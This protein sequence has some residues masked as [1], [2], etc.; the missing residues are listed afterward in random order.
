MTSVLT[1]AACWHGKT[2]ADAQ[3]MLKSG[4]LR[5]RVNEGT[6]DERVVTIELRDAAGG[7]VERKQSGAKSRSADES[8]KS[9]SRIGLIFWWWWWSPYWYWW[10]WAP[11]G[12]RVRVYGPNDST[13]LLD[14]QVRIGLREVE[15]TDVGC[16]IPGD[17]EEKKDKD[18]F[19]LA[20]IEIT[21]ENGEPPM[22]VTSVVLEEREDEPAPRVGITVPRLRPKRKKASLDTV[23]THLNLENVGEATLLV[24]T[25]KEDPTKHPW[26]GLGEARFKYALSSSHLP[27]GRSGPSVSHHTQGV[28]LMLT[29]RTRYDF[30][31]AQISS[32]HPFYI[33]TSPSGGKGDKKRE[34]AQKMEDTGPVFTSLTKKSK[35]MMT[36]I[37]E[38]PQGQKFPKVGYYYQCSNH[39][40]MGG[41]ITVSA[42][43]RTTMLADHYT[44]ALVQYDSDTKKVVVAYS[45]GEELEYGSLRD[46]LAHLEMDICGRPAFYLHSKISSRDM[47]ISPLVRSGAAVEEDDKFVPAVL[48]HT[49]DGSLYCNHVHS[50][51]SLTQWL[52]TDMPEGSGKLCPMCVK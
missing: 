46:A 2:E 28:H 10:W 43:G 20:L 6:P 34:G 52:T 7:F 21:G 33:T 29:E 25:E 23:W 38:V 4:A 3:R 9:S 16:G 50:L 14:R 30:D 39:R 51:A 48:T 5:G 26:S 45:K 22:R 1:S 8:A 31:G 24:T 32:D 18:R 40:F 44:D 36:W 49:A 41:P 42:L 15:S 35:K 27:E 37:P 17:K 12:A 11:Y 19:E 13:D 47:A